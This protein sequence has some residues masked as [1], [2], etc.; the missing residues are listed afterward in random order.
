MYWDQQACSRLNSRLVRQEVPCPGG[1]FALGQKPQW[2]VDKG[3]DTL[4][5]PASPCARFSTPNSWK[6]LS[7][8]ITGI[9]PHMST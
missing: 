3:S 4:N 7:S 1:E 8:V 9:L 2:P 6:Y 5:I